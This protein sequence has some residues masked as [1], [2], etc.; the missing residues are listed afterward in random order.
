MGGVDVGGGGGKRQMNAEINMIPFIDLLLVIIAFLLLT[1]VWVSFS[2]INVNAQV[3]GPPDPD[4][5]ITP[6][7]P[8]KVLHLY[9]R[10][11]EFGLVW[12]QGSTTV[13][14]TS[15]DRPETTGEF[16]KYADLGTKLGEEWKQHGG[17]QDPS[18]RKLDQAIL[19]SDN[20]LKFGQIV[21]VLDA[22][23]STKREMTMKDGKR[24]LQPVFNMTFSVR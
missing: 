3:P 1:A 17:H 11:S 15:I 14:E 9:V 13:S 24:A 22:L 4:K 2:R 23:Y 6:E 20:G 5:E 19:H 10:E 8:E 21:A 12:K 16:I 7:T 18:D